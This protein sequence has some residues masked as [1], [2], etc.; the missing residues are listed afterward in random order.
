MSLLERKQ[1]EVRNKIDVVWEPEPRKDLITKFNNLVNNHNKDVIV[2]NELNALIQKLNGSE[3]ETK[4]RKEI[5]L[6]ERKKDIEDYYYE[7]YTL[8]LFLVQCVAAFTVMGLLGGTLYRYGLMPYA[9][10]MAYLGI[11]AAAAVLVMAYY[12]W[13]FYLR[14]NTIFQEYDFNKI[15]SPYP[16]SP[17]ENVY[18]EL[19]ANLLSC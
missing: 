9:F 17:V 3:I 13:D 8:Q 11:V 6:K 4:K 14:D 16:S 12:L 5:Q 15:H 1:W 19:D 10:L 2:D 18:T 7:E